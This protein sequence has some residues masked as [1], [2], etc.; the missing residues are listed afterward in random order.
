VDTAARPPG[1][2]F[3]LQCGP[4]AVLQPDRQ[5]RLL[6]CPGCGTGQR[7]AAY[8]LF[9]VTGASGTGKST[10]T[11]PLRLRRRP[12]LAAAELDRISPAHLAK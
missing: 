3:C 1:E 9:V 6:Q 12:L 4:G 8:P 2:V 7:L 5:A 10:I 11:G